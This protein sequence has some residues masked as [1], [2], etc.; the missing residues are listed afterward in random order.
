MS[1]RTLYDKVWKSHAVGLLP[2]GQ[3]QLYV[4]R[5]LMHEVTSPQAFEMLRD[6]NIRV[7]S[8]EN[9]FAVIDHIVPTDDP[10]RP[11]ADEQAELMAA[12]LE[13][14]VG[15]FDIN[16]F[17]R[18]S[19]K[20]GVCHVTYPEQGLIWP[21]QVVVCGDSHTSTY[22]AFGVLAFGIGTTQVA[23]VLATQT[24]AMDK[25]NVRKIEFN[26][27]LSEGVAAKELALYLIGELGVEGGIGFAYEFCGET[28]DK[29]DMDE[30]MTLCNLAVEG[31]AR[32]GYVNPDETTVEYLRGK[33]FAPK[34]DFE[35]ATKYWLSIASDSDAI[36]DDIKNLG[37]PLEPM[38]TWGTNPGQ[39]I[40]ISKSIPSLDEVSGEKR[41]E[42]EKA[43]EYMGL[44][45]GDDLLGLPV[46]VVF[47]GSCTNGR[48][49]DLEAAASVLEGYNVSVRT[50]VVPGSELVK[51]NAEQIGL[52]EIFT[53]AGAEWRNPGCSMCLA[54]NPDKLQGQQR[55]A[56]TSNRNFKGRQGSPDGR[57]HLVNPYTAAA[58]AIEGA[59]ASPIS[60]LR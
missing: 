48:L 21:S 50:L 53:D 11:F 59:L 9:T 7:K 54:M 36:Y 37:V 16:Y 8:S 56:S 55:S 34:K 33:P 25:L 22:G 18:N 42:M 41:K 1:E 60:Y 3:T 57:T 24:L 23:Q 38:V 27:N 5:H 45:A 4:G 46:D 30:R 40:G 10:S 47:I 15:E 28:I 13:D 44:S 6:G 43:L 17:K 19:G 20:H 51:Y 31:G 32:V 58:T 2:T 35:R 14:N 39:V 29:L 26:G 49:S 12:T 52:D